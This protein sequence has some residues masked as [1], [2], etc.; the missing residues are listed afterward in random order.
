MEIILVHH[1]TKFYFPFLQLLDILTIKHLWFKIL[2]DKLYSKWNSQHLLLTLDLWSENLKN[3]LKTN[4]ESFSSLPIIGEVIKYYFGSED[5]SDCLLVVFCQ[6]ELST[7]NLIR[8]HKFTI[9]IEEF[10]FFIGLNHVAINNIYWKNMIAP[11]IIITWFFMLIF[12]FELFA[13]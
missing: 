9:I 13:F 10:P 1:L 4:V 8:A 3:C 5:K 2:T 12:I 6:K 11:Q 7:Q